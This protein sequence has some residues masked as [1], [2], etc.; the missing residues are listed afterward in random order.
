MKGTRMI[1]GGVGLCLGGALVAASGRAREPAGVDS[2]TV[3]LA[4]DWPQLEGPGGACRNGGAEVLTGSLA[5]EANGGYD[6]VFDRT[7]RIEFCGTHAGTGGVCA[8]RLDGRGRVAVT[9][10]ILPPDRAGAERRV[11][12]TWRPLAGEGSVEVAGDCPTGFERALE[13]MYLEAPH[14]VEIPLPAGDVDLVRRLE[15]HGWTVRV[16]R[17]AV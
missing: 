14:A 10:T 12:L 6:G 5:P 3:V 13:A 1:V 8:L 9:G 7:T 2:Y 17:P 11:T 15:D 16:A 4:S